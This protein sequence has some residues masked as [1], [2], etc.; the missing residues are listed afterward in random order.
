MDCMCNTTQLLLT[1]ECVIVEKI[2]QET[3]NLCEKK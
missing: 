2:L 3:G 1:P